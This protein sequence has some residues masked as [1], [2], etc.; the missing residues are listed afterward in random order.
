MTTY[1]EWKE[2]FEQADDGGRAEVERRKRQVGMAQYGTPQYWRNAKYIL[3]GW[4][5]PNRET[6]SKL[7][8]L[9]RKG[10]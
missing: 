5:S 3:Q 8:Q 1:D 10:Y 6:Q 2:G 4:T 7:E 9:A